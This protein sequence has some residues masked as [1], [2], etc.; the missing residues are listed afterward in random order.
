MNRALKISVAIGGAVLVI[1]AVAVGLAIASIGGGDDA[2][3]S[4]GGRR[5]EQQFP[6]SGPPGGAPPSGADRKDI[7]AFQDCLA[8]H[9]VELPDP[10]G[11]GGEP[12]SGFDPNAP[13]LQEAFS[14]CEGELPAGVGPR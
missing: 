11:Q 8:E 9:G 13:D 2:A 4:D 12:P 3:S 5:S 1:V 10:R 14:A 7:Q 6:G